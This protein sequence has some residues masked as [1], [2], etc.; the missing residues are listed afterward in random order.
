M[1]VLIIDDEPS[2]RQTVSMILDEEGYEV[3]VA[4]DGKEGLDKA[5]EVGPDMVLTDV[6]MPGMPGLEFLDRYR[7][8]GGDALVIVMTAYGS[9]ELA[10]EAMKKGAYDYIPKPFSAD[11]LVLTIR[12]AQEREALRREVSRLREEVT[13]DRRF[14]GIIAKSPAMKQAVETATKVARYPS[15]VLITGESG[16]GKELIA[17]L[18][19]DQSDRASGNFVAINCGAIP[20]TLLESE[21][22]GHVRGAFT[23]AKTAR[24]GLF[25]QANGGTLFLDEVGEL[26]RHSQQKL[27]RFL[28][29]R[30]VRPVGSVETFE[31]DLRVICATNRRLLDEVRQG[32]FRRDLYY[33]LRVLSIEVPP[34]RQH[35]E[36]VPLLVRHFVRELS[37]RFGKAPVEVAPSV[38]ERMKAYRWPGNVRELANEVKRWVVLSKDGQPVTEALLSPHVEGTAEDDSA[39]GLKERSRDLVRGMLET[40]LE[41]N[42]WNVS[43]TAREL[44]VSRVGLSKKIRRLGLERPRRR[45]KQQ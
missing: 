16:T 22:F 6:R 30:E 9:T 29:R 21:L 25:V 3:L 5:L 2:L 23:D 44:D 37:R 12:K 43:A 1:K 8:E 38:L 45:R 26:C 20:E 31:V 33:R 34:L 15:P 13:V 7:A 40:A 41:R 4:G 10:I 42:G 11:Q 32:S 27:L 28:D 19:H 24:T 39:T 18:I 35:A 14:S 36:D 17:R